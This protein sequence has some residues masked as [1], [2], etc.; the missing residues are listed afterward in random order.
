MMPGKVGEALHVLFKAV[1]PLP[2]RW[3]IAGSCGLALQGVEVT[4]H[5]IDVLT[6]DAGART[7]HAALSEFEKRPLVRKGGERSRPLIGCVEIHE[8]E[9]EIMSDLEA[10][11]KSVWVRRQGLKPERVAFFN[12]MSLPVLPLEDALA[13][14]RAMDRE[15]DHEKVA[16]IE[17][18]LEGR[19]Q[20]GLLYKGHA[21]RPN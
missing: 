21:S 1:D 8:V 19:R 17:A 6:D 9:I 15:K 13:A 16:K 7:I 2:V 12:G 5:D 14:Y 10:D 20:E 18:V 4:P 3:L 11:V